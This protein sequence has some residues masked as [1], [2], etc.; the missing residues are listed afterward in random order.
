MSQSFREQPRADDPR[1]VGEL[2]A[3]TGFFQDHEVAIAIELV[4]ESLVRGLEAG[5][6]YFFAEDDEGLLGYACYGE[7]PCTR[8]SWDLY[9]IAVHPRG[10]RRGLGRALLAATETAIAA[11]AGRAIY[12]ETSSQ[13]LYRPT[14]A[15]YLGAGYELA[16]RFADFYALG[17]DKLVY[18]RALGTDQKAK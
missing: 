9:W 13:E 14:Q 18:R 10:Q 3:A 15:F 6:R 1:A 4:E 7:I 2:V 8:G 17:D 11:L 5:Y 12:I 16:A